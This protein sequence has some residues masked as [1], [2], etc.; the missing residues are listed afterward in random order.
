MRASGSSTETETANAL[1]LAFLR[2]Y[3]DPARLLRRVFPAC[4]RQATALGLSADELRSACLEGVVRASRRYDPTRGDFATFAPWVMRHV[5]EEDVYR[6]QRDADRRGGGSVAPLAGDV[7]GRDGAADADPVEREELV[8]A[9]RAAVVAMPDDD[10]RLLEAVCGLGG[11]EPRSVRG[12]ARDRGL[13]YPTVRAM[14]DAAKGRL[15]R[16]LGERC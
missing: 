2:R 10:R 12:L 9:V 14:V 8:A 6:A 1:V 3:P 11:C 13:P 5:V 7:A 16:V 15:R 4:V